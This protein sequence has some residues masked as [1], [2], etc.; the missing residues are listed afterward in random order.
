MF[1]S[2][3]LPGMQEYGDLLMIFLKKSLFPGKYILKME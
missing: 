3:F 1:K 2:I